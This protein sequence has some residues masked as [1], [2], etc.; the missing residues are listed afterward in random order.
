MFLI[1]DQI[2]RCFWFTNLL[3]VPVL[4]KNNFLSPAVFY[5]TR[6][7]MFIF[8]TSERGA[9]TLEIAPE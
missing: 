4:F 7:N 5:L 6:L 1:V 8:H 9:V 3:N 2:L